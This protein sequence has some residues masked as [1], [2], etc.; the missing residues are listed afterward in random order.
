M[1]LADNNQRKKRISRKEQKARKKQRCQSGPDKTF[2]PS[3]HSAESATAVLSPVPSLEDPDDSYVPTPIPTYDQLRAQHKAKPLGKWFP[4]AMVLKSTLPENLS[5]KASLVLFYQYINPAWPE[6]VVQTLM[7]FLYELAQRRTLG[8][9][10]RVAPEGVNATISS[11]DTENSTAATTLRHF[12]RDLQRFHEGF[13]QTDF[14]FIDGLSTDRH[15]TNFK[16]F[17]VQELVFYGL[18]SEQA[19]LSK[20]GVHLEPNEFHKRLE[21]EGTVVVDVRNHYEALIGRFNGQE[22]QNEKGAAE[23]VDPMMRKSTDFSSWLERPGTQERLRGK[24]VLL[25]CTGGVRCERA[26]AY[27]NQKMGSNLKGVY[28]LRG[29]IERYL[30]A[31]P[32]G[33]HWR[34]K[35]FVFDK[36]EAVGVDNPDGD[37][38]IVRKGMKPIQIETQCCICHKPWDRYIGKKKCE[39]CGVPVLMCDSCM[40]S[41]KKRNPKPLV[42][43]PLCIEENVTVRAEEV[44]YT[45]NGVNVT[46][47]TNT[48]EAKGKM[49]P[50]ILKW[51][52]GH[53]SQKKDKR[54]F[55]GKPCRFGA[56]CSRPDCFFAHPSERCESKSKLTPH[57]A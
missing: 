11:V 32:D 26:S 45:N 34:G 17:P 43:C 6:S 41:I 37:G 3:E 7:G 35:N 4:K 38:G 15:F 57:K 39:T 12:A 25:Y 10:I 42:R 13:L 54:R 29:G 51:G 53:A 52:G 9:R 46:A 1:K 2:S 55:Q 40:S 24:Q 21:D 56:E 44:E 31:F 18:S 22:Q 30:Q 16:M 36:R 19:P 5:S 50:S 47:S 8:G 14:K 49:A 48:S 33:G 27:L 23:Y 20:G 28:Q